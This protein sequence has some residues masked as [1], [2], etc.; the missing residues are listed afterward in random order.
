MEFLAENRRAVEA[1]LDVFSNVRETHHVPPH[2]CLI[3]EIDQTDVSR[4]VCVL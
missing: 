1:V 3:V 2:I 4:A